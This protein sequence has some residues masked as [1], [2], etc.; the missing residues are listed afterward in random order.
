MHSEY[1]KILWIKHHF[2][3]QELIQSARILITIKEQTI[4]QF[5]IKSYQIIHKFDKASLKDLCNQVL[6]KC[7]NQGLKLKFK[8]LITIVKENY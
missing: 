6:V 4:N 8:N 3:F 2:N 5:I 7:K 1:H